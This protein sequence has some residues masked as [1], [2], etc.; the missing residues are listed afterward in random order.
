M[1]KKRVAIQGIRASFHEEAAFK[2]FGT[3][4]ETIEC[5]SFKKTCE[6][7]KNKQADYVVM[8]IENSIAGSLLPNY[9]LLRE[10]NFSIVGEV[11]LAIQL[12]LLAL[13]GVKFEDVKYVQSHPIAIRQ[14]S[15]FFEEFPHLQVVESSDTAACAK[16][17]R[18]ENLT[19]T[20][21]I[22]NLLAAKLYDLEVMERRIESN[23]KNFTR[24]LILANKP[25]ENVEV[26]KASLSFQVGNSVGSLADVLNIFASHKINLSK[27]QSMPVLGKRNEYNFYVD[28]EWKNQADYDSAIRQV[29]KHTI[30]FTIMG[31][32]L[33]N[34]KV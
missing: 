34:D 23:K 25:L 15:D 4:I 8:A 1:Q 28:I 22:A 2:F 27:I 5:E 18:E 21:A 16:K 14:C 33:K 20:V 9:T 13:P 7:L 11:Y 30:N 24:F 19:D 29:L 10:Y 12:H 31:E 3:D 32:Y 26:N 6:V 17:I